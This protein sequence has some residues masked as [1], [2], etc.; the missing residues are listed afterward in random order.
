MDRVTAAV[1]AFYEAYPYPPGNRPDCDAYHGRLLLSYI[2]RPE[3]MPKQL[4]LL[5]A[6]CGRG[7]NLIAAAALQPDDQ[8]TGIDIN[9]VAIDEASA[10]IRTEAL[11]NLSFQLAD[12][13]NPASL[14]G[15]SRGYDVIL[16]YGVIH[17][18]SDPLKGLQQLTQQLAPHGV[19]SLMV[20]GRYGRQ[21]LDRF[22]QALEMIS[23]SAGPDEQRAATARALAR[24]AERGLFQGNCW[25]GTSS[26]DEVEFADRCLHVHE[27]SY[28]IEGL[29]QLLD[30][31]GLKFIRWHQPDD[32]SLKKIFD[33]EALIEQLQAI[34][35][36]MA[37]Q[38][39][40]RLTYRPKLT[41]VVARKE[42]QPRLPLT[43]EAFL[44]KRFCLSPQLKRVT[45]ESGNTEWLLRGRKLSI[46][47]Q[48][49]PHQLLTAASQSDSGFTASQLLQQ[50]S[51][52]SNNPQQGLNLFMQLYD[53]ECLYAPHETDRTL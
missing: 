32:W 36:S 44:S 20:D 16:S 14:P 1:R 31:A 43:R 49:L 33:D 52:E 45:D 6:G 30:M 40:E 47:A 2:E 24:V 15:V 29:W 28:D 13:L 39:I 37:Y 11:A 51:G 26:V 27:Q 35:P 18:L 8:F 19:M 34:E 46:A 41:L 42:E 23:P 3:G 48:G 53:L 38:L 25:Q 4:Q 50:L 22:L 9:R 10:N 7:I 17:H 21:P 5:E 12:L